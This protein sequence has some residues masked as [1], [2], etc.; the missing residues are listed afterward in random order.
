MVTQSPRLVRRDD[1]ALADRR[2]PALFDEEVVE[3]IL[4]LPPEGPL[5][6]AVQA[7][8]TVVEA[9]LGDGCEEV[10]VGLLFVDDVDRR[11]SVLSVRRRRGGRIAA[12]NSAR[13]G[14]DSRDLGR[15]R[16]GPCGPQYS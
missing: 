6:C 2:L 1:L 12:Q 3:L 11:K 16:Q 14:P 8:V 9:A 7:E 4:T 15:S 5:V 10:R 13:D